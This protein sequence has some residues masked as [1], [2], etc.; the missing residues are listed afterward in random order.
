MGSDEMFLEDYGQVRALATVGFGGGGRPR[1]TARVEQVLAS[2][3]GAE[4]A[5]LVHGAGTGAIRAML[6][7]GVK[8]ES[9]IIVHRGQTYKTTVATMRHM[10]LK[11]W[12]MNFNSAE[13]VRQAVRDGTA[14]GAYIQHVP[15]G[16]GDVQDLGE[17]ITI[18]RGALGER[19]VIMVDECYAAM[20]A[21]LSGVQLGADVSALSLFKLLAA[22]NI[23]CVAGRE[24]IVAAIRRDLS[25]AG[26]QVEGPQAMEALRSLVYAPVALA[27]Q[28]QVVEETT[29]RINE[30]I[31]G[32]N[33]P[34]V[35]KAL[36]AQPGSRCVVLLFDRPLADEFLQSAWRNGSP[37]I[38]I[39]EESRYEVIPLFTVLPSTFLRATPE[40]K[41]FGIR[42]NPM[43]GGPAT[44]VAVLR[45]ALADEAFRSAA[46]NF[47]VQA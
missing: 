33:L 30:L 3:F 25:S 10:G 2:F 21:P 44:I 46:A 32:G 31:D 22:Q 8:P 42:I 38:S 37:S 41:E 45:R 34:T 47:P 6:N 35:R 1:A 36:A 29:R 40:L 14:D 18:F 28:D 4:D 13:E 12:P 26:C 23:G 39:G 24:E 15:Q 9:R 11:L 19:V 20:R 27:L 17:L 5:A 7:A 43:R 16:L